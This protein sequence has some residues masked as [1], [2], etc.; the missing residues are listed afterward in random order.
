MGSESGTQD[1]C[2]SDNSSEDDNDN[3]S[4]S[5]SSSDGSFAKDWDEMLLN[6]APRVRVQGLFKTSLGLG[7]YF[8]HESSHKSSLNRLT[9]NGVR[10]PTTN[11][12]LKVT[13]RS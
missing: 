5:S 9:S 12:P 7:N 3:R 1:D 10:L 6:D 13:E 2:D 11:H 4:V 8:D